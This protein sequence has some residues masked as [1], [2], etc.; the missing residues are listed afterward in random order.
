MVT[1][2]GF[3]IRS[4]RWLSVEVQLFEGT[5]MEFSRKAK[6]KSKYTFA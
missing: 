3:R 6:K 2:R 1:L 5:C 4:D